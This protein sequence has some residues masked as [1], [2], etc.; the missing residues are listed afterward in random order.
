MGT[1]LPERLSSS[2][3]TPCPPFQPICSAVRY[4][5]MQETLCQP[6]WAHQ[7]PCPDSPRGICPRRPSAHTHSFSLGREQQL[8]HVPQPGERPPVLPGAAGGK[9]MPVCCWG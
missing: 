4:G 3:P 1:E 6:S 2:I 8:R 5:Q 7:N 9:W